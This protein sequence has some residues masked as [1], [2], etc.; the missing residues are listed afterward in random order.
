[1]KFRTL[2]IIKAIVCLGFGPLLLFAPGPLLTLLGVEFNSGAAFMGREYGAALVGNLLL[3]WF[4]KDAGPSDAR[5]AIILH[6][7]VYDAIA[8]VASLLFQLSGGMNLLG[9]GIVGIYLFFTVG[10]GYFWLAK[11][12]PA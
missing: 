4:A 10:F 5:R 7:F 9:W 8:F 3:T 12:Q 2:M 1:M 11:K 6:L